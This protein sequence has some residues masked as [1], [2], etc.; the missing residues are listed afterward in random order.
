MDP[1]ATRDVAEL[2]AALQGR[3]DSPLL[4]KPAELA[5]LVRTF[6]QKLKLE[7]PTDLADAITADYARSL[8]KASTADVT[9]EVSAERLKCAVR[10]ALDSLV[11]AA[12]LRGGSL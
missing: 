2:V 9:E 1:N 12:I 4:G 3:G 11:D 8:F 5:E 6:H 7:L 10:A